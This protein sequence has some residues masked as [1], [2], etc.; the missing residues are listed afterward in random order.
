[1]PIYKATSKLEY[2]LDVKRM[3]VPNGEY[4]LEI[5]LKDLNS[6]DSTTT[7]KAPFE[8]NFSTEEIQFSQLQFSKQIKKSTEINDFSKHGIE[9][10]PHP[11]AYYPAEQ[12][13]LAFYVELYNSQKL[14]GEDEMFLLEFKVLS[15]EDGEVANDIRSF[16]RSTTA[17]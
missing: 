16:T 5:F 10:I 6:T 4:E 12:D 9:I 14:L 15:V 11:S 13:E 1:S 3:S 8:L 2:L 17:E 7:V